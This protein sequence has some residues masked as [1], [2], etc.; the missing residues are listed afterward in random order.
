MFR[1]DLGRYI[2]DSKE[3]VAATKS[4]SRAQFAKEKRKM[5]DQGKGKVVVELSSH[6]GPQIDGDAPVRPAMSIGSEM[7]PGV[8]LLPDVVELCFHKGTD[9]NVG[10]PV[11]RWT[12]GHPV[13]PGRTDGPRWAQF[14]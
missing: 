10:R 3:D 2:L 1:R 7:I 14:P 8:L 4:R 6:T 12:D 11:G 13:G 9:A 5:A